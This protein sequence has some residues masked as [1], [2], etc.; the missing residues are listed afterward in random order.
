MSGQ[1]VDGGAFLRKL[2]E[3]AGDG[4]AVKICGF[5]LEQEAVDACRAGADALGINF[6]P[7]SK[8][9]I[10]FEESAEWLPNLPGDVSRIGIFVNEDVDRV[11][12][13][14]MSGHIDA[15]QLHGDESA[16][17][18]KVLAERG[19]SFIKA[20][21]VK[22]PESLNGIDGYHTPWIL[23]DAWCPGEYGGS[24]KRFDQQLATATVHRFPHLRV[25]LSGGLTPDNVSAA[26]AAVKPAAVDVA[27]GVEDSPGR[28][29]PGMVRRFISEAQQ[30]DS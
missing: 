24:G 9:F 29:N 16:D 23:L 7:K 8:R 25:V 17:Y 15:A 27:S 12:E 30:A 3:G 19:I 22:D 13:I 6:Y 5:T 1:H 14:V 28:K 21:G 26:V 20:F 2:R 4:T 10:S 18:C 11:S